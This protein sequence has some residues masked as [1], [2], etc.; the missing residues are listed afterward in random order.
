MAYL[1]ELGIREVRR[2][3]TADVRRQRGALDAGDRRAMSAIQLRGLA[4]D[5]VRAF[6]VTAAGLLLAAAASRWP[7]VTVRGAVLVTVVLI[8]AGIG[9]AAAGAM[10]LS[11]PG[12]GLRWFALGL[13]AGAAWV[14]VL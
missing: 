1:G 12:F 13:V 11:G 2:R 7:P 10:R 3:N 6:T 14:I 5:A 9:A 8:G 4:R